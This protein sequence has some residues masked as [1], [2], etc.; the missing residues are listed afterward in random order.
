[1]NPPQVYMSFLTISFSSDQQQHGIQK[2]HRCFRIPSHETD[3][4]PR[5]EDHF[6]QPVPVHV[7]GHCPGKPAHHPGHHL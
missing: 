5:T 2:S 6:L 7:P 1:M 4:G 3:R